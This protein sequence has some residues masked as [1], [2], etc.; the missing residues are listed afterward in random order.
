M[1]QSWNHSN[2]SIIQL[3]PNWLRSVNKL[4]L[5]NG[6]AFGSK[7]TNC[8]WAVLK[9]GTNCFWQFSCQQLRHQQ[10][11]QQDHQTKSHESSRHHQSA[12]D[13]WQ[14]NTGPMKISSTPHIV[15]W[16]IS[17]SVNGHGDKDLG[18]LFLLLV[19]LALIFRGRLLVL[20]VLG[21]KV[22]H[23]GLGLWNMKAR[24]RCE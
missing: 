23:V 15:Y 14:G 8:R 7:S 19:E 5:G 16:Q 13:Y 4:S 18:L 17:S 21:D 12:V 6:Q 1:P 2:H 10:Y 20:L 9:L 22:V 11:H 3:L 24:W